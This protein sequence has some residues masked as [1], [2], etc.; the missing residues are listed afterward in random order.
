MGM[1]LVQAQMGLTPVFTEELAQAQIWRNFNPIAR[2]TGPAL[3]N[4]ETGP[5]LAL[6]ERRLE[7]RPERRLGE[8]SA[9]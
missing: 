1:G 8:R 9:G 5:G 6:G 4:R 7:G 2:P 3:P